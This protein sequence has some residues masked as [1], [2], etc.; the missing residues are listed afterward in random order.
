MAGAR[1]WFAETAGGG[2]AG[3]VA[4]SD[5]VRQHGAQRQVAMGL[6][7]SNLRFFWQGMAER[8]GAKMWSAKV[9]TAASRFRIETCALRK[10]KLEIGGEWFMKASGIGEESEIGGHRPP[11]QGRRKG[12]HF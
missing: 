4:E 10:G 11:L 9:P 7:K 2:A 1:R 8:C 12:M 6:R 3:F 5:N